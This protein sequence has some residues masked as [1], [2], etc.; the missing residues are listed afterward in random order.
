MIYYVTL[1]KVS[2]TCLFTRVIP[3]HPTLRLEQHNNGESDTPPKN[4]LKLVVF[5]SFEE[6]SHAF[7]VRKKG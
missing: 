4:A 2:L 7:E 6:Q 3:T 5:F 1:S